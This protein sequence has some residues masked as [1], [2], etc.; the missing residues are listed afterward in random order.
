MDD[1]R[2]R[3]FS[4][5]DFVDGCWIW[6]GRSIGRG[7]NPGFWV[8]GRYRQARRI[9]WD[10]EEFPPL[11]PTDFLFQTCDQPLCVRPSHMR[12]GLRGSHKTG[13]CRRGHPLTE[14]NIY[15]TTQGKRACR[16]CIRTKLDERRKRYLEEGRGWGKTYRPLTPS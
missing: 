7:K 3:F 11:G 15:V 4:K 6:V 10:I 1:T 16:I 2:I 13:L 9:A 5:V 12:V 14:D 8:D